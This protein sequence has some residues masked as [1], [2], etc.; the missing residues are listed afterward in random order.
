MINQDLKNYGYGRKEPN[1]NRMLEI[2]ATSITLAVFG[3]VVWELQFHPSNRGQ[4]DCQKCHSRELQKRD[5]LANYFRKNGSKTPEEMAEAVL[6]TKSPRLMA[7][8]HV[9][10]E[11]STPYWVRKGGYK[12]RHA[13]AWQQNESD[14]GAVPYDLNA[15]AIKAENDLEKLITDTGDFE[16]ALNKWGGDKSKKVYAANILRELQEVPR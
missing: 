9:K 5:K 8:I 13:G 4:L 15:Q 12:K 11:K 10:G 1:Y 16:T 7:A 14:W 3:L 6:R 2:L